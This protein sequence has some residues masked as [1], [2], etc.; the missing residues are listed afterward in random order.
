MKNAKKFSIILILILLCLFAFSSCGE[1]NSSFNTGA[2]TTTEAQNKPGPEV[3]K[4]HAEY[5]ISDIDE[6]SMAEEDKMLLSMLAG[7][8]MFEMD[9]EFCEDGI[10]T[11]TI[12]T[13]EIKESISNSVSKI[14]S[15]FIDI[16]LSLF[17]N[18]LIEAVFEDVL[19]STQSEYVGEYTTSD[20]ELIIA[21][22]DGLLKGSEEAVLYF[23]MISRRIV[24]VDEEGNQAFVFKQSA[25][26]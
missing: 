11:Y 18:R 8:I 23:R 25:D 16:D 4:W 1:A 22:D 10:F 5:K 13:D 2:E 7:N 24:Q 15:L 9:V 3:G 20:N 21:K 6:S 12:N 14:A 26:N 17:T 19:D